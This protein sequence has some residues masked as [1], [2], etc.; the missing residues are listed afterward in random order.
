MKVNYCYVFVAALSYGCG[1]KSD[2]TSTSKDA[3]FK[4]KLANESLDLGVGLTTVTSIGAKLGGVDLIADCAG[5]TP[6]GDCLEL[7]LSPDPDIW[8]N[9]GCDGDLAQCTTSNTAYFELVDPSAANTALNSQGRSIEAGTFTKVRI[10]LLNNDDGS[11]LPAMSSK[12][13]TLGQMFQLHILF[14]KRSR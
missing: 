10:Y 14:P 2:T 9:E 8:V 7:G 13:A 4:V 3:S 5:D 12:I 1:K 6:P 11:H